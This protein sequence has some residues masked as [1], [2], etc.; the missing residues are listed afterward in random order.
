MGIADLFRPNWK[1]SSHSVRAAAVKNMDADRVDT[2]LEIAETDPDADIRNLALERVQDAEALEAF[3]DRVSDKPLAVTARERADTLWMSAATQDDDVG[4][5][6]SAL[7][8][9]SG[10]AALSDV[11]RRSKLD[12]IRRLALERMQDPRSLAEVVKNVKDR[13]LANLALSQIQDQA[14]LRGLVLEEQRRDIAASA[15]DRIEDAE[16]LKLLAQR[17]KVKAIQTK[18]RRKLDALKAPSEE[19]KAAAL[20]Q[21]KLH[22]RIVQV[23]RRVEKVVRSTD[24]DRAAQQLD[25]LRRDWDTLCGQWTDPEQKLVE[26]FE[27][28]TKGFEL[29]HEQVTTL[30]EAR[31]EPV[32]APEAVDEHREDRAARDAVLER[33]IALDGDDAQEQLEELQ[34]EW[35][36]LGPIPDAYQAEYAG[37]F[38]TARRQVQRSQDREQD[39]AAREAAFEELLGEATASLSLERTGD[40]RKAFAMHRRDWRQAEKRFGRDD[41]FAG[42][43]E[44]LEVQVRERENDERAAQES[45]RQENLEGLQRLLSKAQEVADQRSLAKVDRA[46]RDIR[47]ALK[48]PG[49]VP[50]KSDWNDLKPQFQEVRDRLVVLLRELRDADGW[51]RWANTSQQ[52]QLIAEAEALMEVEELAEVAK[53]LRAAQ[54]AWKKLGPGSRKKGD[55]LWQKFKTTCDQVHARCEVYFQEQD[56]ARQEALEKKTALCEQVEALQDSEEWA[57]TAERIK[58]LQAE[59]KESGP[60]PR[61]LSDAIWKRFRGACDHFFERRKVAF[62][63]QDAQREQNLE[64]KLA[65]CERAEALRDSDQWD[66]TT[67]KIKALQAEWKAIGPVPRRKS[68]AIWSRFRGTCDHFFER[69]KDYQDEGR[70]ENLAKRKELLDELAR[71]LD[72]GEDAAADASK[73]VEAWDKWKTLSPVPSAEEAPTQERFRVVL[74]RAMETL[75]AGFLGTVLDPMLTSQK[76][77]SLCSKAEALAAEVDEANGDTEAE[78][79]DPQDAEAMA[80]K[81]KEALAAS[82]FRKEFQQEDA[83]R[84]AEQGSQL[85]RSWDRLAPLPGEESE[86]LT[87]RFEKAYTKLKK[88]AAAAGPR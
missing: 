60:V 77:E 45:R 10:E 50:Q 33:V 82:A 57:E 11:V 27:T 61:K 81:L 14:I 3:A 71:L 1:H 47:L 70:S 86:Q 43:F 34:K 56:Q 17:A 24:W 51:K 69:R 80:A 31:A 19:E 78:A 12:A 44:A 22:A 84:I 28:L 53:R 26:R 13:E 21:K 9:V 63:E 7:A 16:S 32:V 83:Q 15:L 8:R 48:K 85:K 68:D 87:A 62:K 67:A 66:E 6:E 52:E 23:L 46:L 75:R 25:E 40:L 39:R 76:M 29:R 20:E 55:E 65:L 64:K 42:R 79:I 73:F 36:A 38:D 41:A 58:A 37:R 18:A 30:R 74:S 4:V 2:L 59:W 49:P 72:A 5:A 88:A 54:A 35:E